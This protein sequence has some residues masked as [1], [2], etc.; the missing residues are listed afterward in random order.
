[1]WNAPTD[2]NVGD[3]PWT[4]GCKGIKEDGK[5]SDLNHG[6]RHQERGVSNS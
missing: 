1:M 6:S 2:T 4:N 3:N 5:A